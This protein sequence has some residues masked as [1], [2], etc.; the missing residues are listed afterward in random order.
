MG[1]LFRR[2]TTDAVASPVG[3]GTDDGVPDQAVD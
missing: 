3:K 1:T 2:V